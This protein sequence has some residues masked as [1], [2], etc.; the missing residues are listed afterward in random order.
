MINHDVVIVDYGIGNLLSVRRGFEYCGA[1]VT[2]SSDPDL[3]LSSP[4]VVLP[5]VGAFSDAMSELSSQGLDLVLKRVANQGTPLMGICLGM[6][7]LFD[8]SDEFGVTQGLGLISGR[9][10][11]IPS[12]TV[13]GTPQKIPHIGWNSLEL[14]QGKKYWKSKVL[15]DLKVGDTVYFA[16]SY[17]A[18][19]EDESHRIADCNYGGYLISAVVENK[20]VIGCQFHPEKSGEVGLSVLRQF[21][22]S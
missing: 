9:V 5:G 19:P 16:H 12:K 10:S 21:L 11:P 14:P 17:M 18:C 2:I 3:I 1:V 13:Y 15:K 7:L 22:K 4:R 8:E 6:Q 20:N